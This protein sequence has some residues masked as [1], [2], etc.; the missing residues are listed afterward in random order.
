MGRY[1][2]VELKEEATKAS[3]LPPVQTQPERFWVPFGS[4]TAM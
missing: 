2:L 3:C 1:I 4:R